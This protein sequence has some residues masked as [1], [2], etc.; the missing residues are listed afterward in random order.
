MEVQATGGS[1]QGVPPR[2]SP[3]SRCANNTLF[4]THHPEHKSSAETLLLCVGQARQ[5]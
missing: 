3:P 5:Q 2:P 1:L 4:L